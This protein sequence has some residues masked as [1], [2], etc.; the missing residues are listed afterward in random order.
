MWNSFSFPFNFIEFQGFRRP[1]YW[2]FFRKA[3]SFVIE[4]KSINNNIYFKTV[5]KWNYENI[6]SSQIFWTTQ[7]LRKL[8]KKFEISPE[9]TLKCWTIKIFH[10]SSREII[11]FWMI[12]RDWFHLKEPNI[13]KNQEIFMETLKTNWRLIWR[14]KKKISN[15]WGKIMKINNDERAQIINWWEKWWLES[16]SIDLITWLFCLI[17]EM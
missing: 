11:I 15:N 7:L 6:M 16:I 5:K 14:V 4:I 10:Q 2:I 1:F 13:L 8:F 12:A 17:Y 9:K 3:N